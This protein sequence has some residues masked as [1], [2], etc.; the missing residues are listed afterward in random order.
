MGR[1]LYRRGARMTGRKPYT[2]LNR[3]GEVVNMRL[4]D[5]KSLRN[6][7][8]LGT[9]DRMYFNY[10][11]NY[12][13]KEESIFLE[14]YGLKTTVFNVNNLREYGHVHLHPH[15]IEVVLKHGAVDKRNKN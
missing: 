2:F 8:K 3:Y 12:C 11:Y 15:F 7:V 5:I 4:N 10:E 13:S 6:G 14:K 9:Y 1:T